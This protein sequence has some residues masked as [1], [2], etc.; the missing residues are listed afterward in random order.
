MDASCQ[1]VVVPY[2]LVGIERACDTMGDSGLRCY[3]FVLMRIGIPILCYKPLYD[4]AH[5]VLNSLNVLSCFM[6]LP[7]CQ[8]LD[9]NAVKRRQTNR[10]FCH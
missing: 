2:L 8:L 4:V 5:C 7:I 6:L 3:E 1:Q 10:F 9:T